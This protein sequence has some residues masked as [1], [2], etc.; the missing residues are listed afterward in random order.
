MIIAA[1][2]V[3]IIAFF[4]YSLHLKDVYYGYGRAVALIYKG[5]AEVTYDQHGSLT[6]NF[7]NGGAEVYLCHLGSSVT[8]LLRKGG[9]IDDSNFKAMPDYSDEAYDSPKPPTVMS[10]GNPPR[11][12]SLAA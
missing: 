5:K 10:A 6:F 3:M 7:P 11:G 2:I 1:F 9:M 8:K 12:A 4:L